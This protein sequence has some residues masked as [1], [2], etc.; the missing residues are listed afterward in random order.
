MRR[1]LELIVLGIIPTLIG[2][3]GG[4]VLGKLD[5]PPA[6]VLHETV[7]PDYVNLDIKF[8][9]IYVS[10]KSGEWLLSLDDREMKTVAKGKGPT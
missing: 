2:L 9:T 10:D 8:A 7:T 1:H 5:N 6:K 4:F 3:C